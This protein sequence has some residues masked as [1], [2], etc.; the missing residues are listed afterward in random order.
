MKVFGICSDRMRAKSFL[1]L[2]I[3]DERLNHRHFPKEGIL[4]YRILNQ[5]RR[6][7]LVISV[8]CLQFIKKP[9]QMQRPFMVSEYITFWSYQNCANLQFCDIYLSVDA[10]S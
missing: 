4:T 9:L 6:K 10:V 3:F 5:M 7:R 2:E 8:H 1:E